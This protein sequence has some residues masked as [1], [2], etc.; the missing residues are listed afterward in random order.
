MSMICKRCK[1]F[2]PEGVKICESCG[3]DV[4]T[5]KIFGEIS[6]KVENKENSTK[7]VIKKGKPLSDPKKLDKLFVPLTSISSVVLFFIIFIIIFNNTDFYISFSN[8]INSW[9]P[10]KEEL[11]VILPE[12]K[13]EPKKVVKKDFDKNYV[14][15]KKRDLI[16]YTNSKDN[17]VMILIPSGEVVIGS[18]NESQFEMPEH[19][20]NIE[21]FYIDEH[22]VTNKQYRKFIEETGY[23]APDY[24]TDPRFS[25]ANQPVVGVSFKDASAY[26]EWAGKRLPSEAEWE[27]AARGGLINIP[28]PYSKIITAKDFCYN[29]NPNT[30]HPIDVKRLGANDFKLYDISGNV[31][32]WTTS[33]PYFY[34]S[35]KPMVDKPE[36]F[37]VIR[38]GSWKSN[39]E[40]LTNSKRKFSSVQ[41]KRNDLG[42][43]CVMDY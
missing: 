3:A 13:E 18:N 27:K 42:F 33:I 1:S 16:T 7:P 40:D 4:K 38:G 19:E 28:Y 31:Y 12:L 23:K 20:V 15:R 6:N 26:A 17:M 9:L 36:N 11:V 25:G 32:E 34:N 37:R 21:A 35:G 5:G 41:T 24:L 29:L 2:V 22:E 30:G 8:F 43:R 14:K 10:E 39:E